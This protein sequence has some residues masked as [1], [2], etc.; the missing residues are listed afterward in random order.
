MGHMCPCDP[1]ARRSNRV[2]LTGHHFPDPKKRRH[3]GSDDNTL[4]NPSIADLTPAWRALCSNMG[5][6]SDLECVGYWKGINGN[7]LAAFGPVAANALNSDFQLLARAGGY[8]HAV[9]AMK[10]EHCL[11]LLF[12]QGKI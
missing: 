1:P 10:E 7:S 11:M 9:V 12:L 3:T 5:I 4:C 6:T 2:S 8:T